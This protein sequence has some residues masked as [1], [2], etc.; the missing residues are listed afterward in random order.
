MTP[1][2]PP[3]GAPTVDAGPRPMVPKL[4]D[5]RTF[6]LIYHIWPVASNDLWRWNITRLLPRID[7]FNG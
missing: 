6:N 1:L 5:I 3:R 4:R 7:I 2:P